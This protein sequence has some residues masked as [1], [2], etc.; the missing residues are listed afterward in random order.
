MEDLT[1]ALVAASAITGAVLILK[2]RH[3]AGMFAGGI[4]LAILAAEYPR[5]F[6]KLRRDLRKFATQGLTLMEV[7]SRIGER[8][9][10]VSERRGGV[11]WWERLA[12]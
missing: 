11:E 7:A 8:I 6:A 3:S 12:S 4:G 10:E 9:A 5:E 2:G 1:R